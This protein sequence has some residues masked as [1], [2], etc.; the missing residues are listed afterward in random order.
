MT[1]TY[2]G[3]RW[4]STSRS[5]GITTAVI[6]HVFLVTEGSSPLLC[7][8]DENIPNDNKQH[9]DNAT[10]LCNS[11]NV[12]PINEGDGVRSGNYIVS[13]SYSNSAN[14]VNFENKTRTNEPWND[15]VYNRTFQGIES[16]TGI[17]KA[18]DDNDAPDNPTLPYLNSAGD[19][20]EIITSQVNGLLSFSYNLRSFRDAWIMNLQATVNSAGITVAGFDIPARRGFLRSLRSTK[21]IIT[22]DNENTTTYYRIDVEIEIHKKI[23]QLEPVDQGYN[24]IEGGKKYRIYT[25]NK[26]VFGKKSD[27][28][29]SDEAVPVDTPVRLDGAGDIF[30]GAL[31]EVKFLKFNHFPQVDW[32]II[33][34]PKRR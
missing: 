27:F 21:Q 28:P 34:F 32:S 24:F 13:C 31:D 11:V 15:P 23:I 33:N 18:Y 22:D 4:G 9:P 6:D 17:A 5:N 10:L 3:Q 2:M 1:I 26:G 19:V 25:N 20:L 14:T 30:P 29:A 16:P 8:E 12:T 7:L